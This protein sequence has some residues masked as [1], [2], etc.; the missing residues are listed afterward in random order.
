MPQ[1]KYKVTK[2]FTDKAGKTWKPGDNYTPA[3]DAEAQSQ[4]SQGNVSEDTSQQ[5][6]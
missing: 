1:K 3:N 2:Q 4:V 6:Q 5:S